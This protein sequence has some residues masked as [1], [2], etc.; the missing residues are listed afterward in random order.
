MHLGIQ[1]LLVHRRQLNSASLVNDLCFANPGES[2]QNIA[3]FHKFIACPFSLFFSGC[4]SI[5]F[6]DTLRLNSLC[7]HAGI[8][9]F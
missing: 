7:R 6:A 2:V 3:K 5:G 4:A 8:R 1:I 9:E